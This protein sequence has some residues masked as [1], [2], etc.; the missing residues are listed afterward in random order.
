M[1]GSISTLG[2]GSGLQ[3]QDI[4]EQLRAVDEQLINRKKDEITVTSSKIN[5][6]TTVNNK[7]LTMKSSALNLSLSSNY[8][9]RTIASSDEKVLTA[10]V[11]DGSDV[12][13]QSVTVDRIASKSSWTSAGA[14]SKD[15]SVYV[16][17][18]QESTT[19]VA[20]A[21]LGTTAVATDGTLVIEYGSSSTI[22][23]DVGPSV[24]PLK[25]ETMDELVTAI[26]GDDENVGGGANG[27]LV[28]ASTYVVGAETF[29]RIESDIAADTGEDARVVIG[30][31]DTSLAFAP[32][33]PTE[34]FSV[35]MDGTTFS[36]DV[37][38]DTTLSQLADLINDDLDNPGFTASIIDDGT[39]SPFKLVLQANETGSDQE[40]T[41]LS[42][43]TDSAF[44]VDPLKTG[45]NLNSSVTID[46]I[47]YQRQNNTISDVLSGITLSL[48]G[49]GTSALAVSNND[50]EVL[51]MVNSLVT[52][53]N[54]VVQEVGTQVGYNETTKSFGALAGTTV[55]DLPYA[56]QNLMTG[57]NLAD[58]T[59]N[60]ENLFDLGLE[61]QRDGSITIDQTKLST[62]IADNP[63]GVKDFFVGT[64]T[65]ID[66]PRLETTTGV[67][68]ASV[69]S[70]ADADG[71]LVLQYGSDVG[72]TITID[73]TA[74][75]TLND[76][77][78][79]INND[80]ENSGNG[81]NNQIITAST[82]TTDGT[83]YLLLESAN[84]S[85]T[86]DATKIS[87]TTNGTNLTFG[88]S[89]TR[90]L[91]DTVEGFADK[92][93]NYLRAVTAAD[94][95]LFAEK[96]SA[97]QRVDDLTLRIEE[98]TARLDKRYDL[99]AQRFVALDSYMSQMTSV[100]NYLTGQFASLS[101]G[102][103]QVSSK[104]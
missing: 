54:G 97:E 81:T 102:W 2:I 50:G 36:L 65:Q 99:L 48:Q 34:L 10:T 101:D 88:V 30:T 38:A 90:Y 35:Q 8:L 13:E 73:L 22:T 93:N 98:E 26:N 45:E 51:N 6:F 15:A 100:A 53:Y 70:I 41:F 43:L 11:L 66:V 74:G 75:D 58:A 1:A 44:T 37:T 52:A 12:Q 82:Y 18:T 4:L 39:A 42:Q 68:S 24:L 17:K 56:L 80:A 104:D 49:E 69:G 28:T 23:V 67:A 77:V 33:P 61:F 59:G 103:G 57:S 91:Y 72:D 40:I 87:A 3:L 71:T 79:A 96:S 27:R 63:D 47:T 85:G 32:A 7:L 78:A 64:S 20:T 95:Q 62:A 60:I 94:G 14:A 76:L 21:D 16:P 92:A 89:S 46:N 5:Q 25:V 31:N 83:T 19:G 9:K 55:R 29:L 84:T 86:G